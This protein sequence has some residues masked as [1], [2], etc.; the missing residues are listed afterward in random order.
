MRQ[1]PTD[2]NKRNTD[3]ICGDS[4]NNGGKCAKNNE[5]DLDWLAAKN[6]EVLSTL[7]Q[8]AK[9]A[10]GE[11]NVKLVRL[12]DLHRDAHR[13][14]GALNEHLL[15]LAARNHHGVQQELGAL[16]GGRR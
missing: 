6:D 15:L 7:G 2:I 14:D 3:N 9:E 8:E 13:V 5:T 1:G 4:A 12:L 11:D 16:P 10:T